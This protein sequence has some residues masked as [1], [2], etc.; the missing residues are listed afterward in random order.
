MCSVLNITIKSY[1]SWKSRGESIRELENKKILTKI[2]DIR[3]DKKKRC[4]GSLKIRLELCDED[5]NFNHKRIARIMR[6]NNIFAELRRNHRY[7]K[8]GKEKKDVAPNILNRNFNPASPNK[9]W[10][11]DITYIPTYSGW[12]YLCSV[13]DLFGKKIVGWEVSQSPNTELVIKAI[14]KAIERRNPRKGLIIHSD[15]GCQYTSSKYIAF[16]KNKEF[17]QSMSRRGNCWDNACIESFFGH[18]KNEWLW[19]FKFHSID[20]VRFALFEYIDGFYN[21]I[22]YHA[23]NNYMSPA[24]YEKKYA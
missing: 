4:Y 14:K 9:V 12:V 21:T 19:D 5:C 1:Y 13:M 17:L 18:L 3:E 8:T 24:D 23:G 2:I 20:E 16:L 6:E 15:Q 11:S 22:R 10:T 7:K